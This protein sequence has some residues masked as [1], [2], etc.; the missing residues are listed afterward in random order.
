L[1]AANAPTG[2][3]RRLL[4]DQLAQARPHGRQWRLSSR[5]PCCAPAAGI[6]LDRSVEP[7]TSCS[8]AAAARAALDGE[9][10]LTA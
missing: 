7:A 8:P 4:E 2:V 3:D 6:V 10:R 1:F 5:R 9:A